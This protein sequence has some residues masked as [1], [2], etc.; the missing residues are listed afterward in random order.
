MEDETIHGVIT[1]AIYGVKCVSA[2]SEVAKEKLANH[3][4]PEDTKLEDTLKN[5]VHDIGD[6]KEDEVALNRLTDAADKVFKSVGMEEK[7]LD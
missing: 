3:I 5:S 1:T 4:R 2:Q 7:R 6:S